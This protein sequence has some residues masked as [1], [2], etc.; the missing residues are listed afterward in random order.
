MTEV[1]NGTPLLRLERIW[2][3]ALAG[4]VRPATVAVHP[5]EVVAAASVDLHFFTCGDEQRYADLVTGLQAGG[6]GAAGGAV[7][8]YAGLGVLDDQ[9][10]RTRGS[11]MVE[12]RALVH[13]DD[14]SKPP[15]G[16]CGGRRTTSG[17]TVNLVYV[18]VS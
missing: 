9:L 8:L 5:A 13:R 16:S 1:G 14:R 7:A 12:R 3:G 18:S 6:L 10:G 11:S 2:K 17:V 4:L 15:A